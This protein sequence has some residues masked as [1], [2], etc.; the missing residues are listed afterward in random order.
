MQLCPSHQMAA[1]PRAMT[2]SGTGLR[3]PT[4]SGGPVERPR[5][6][7]ASSSGSDGQAAAQGHLPALTPGNCV[8]LCGPQA[9]QP[10]PI[11]S[12]AL[13]TTGDR[14]FSR[15]W[16]ARQ[17]PCP[18]DAVA[19]GWSTDQ[20]D[21]CRDGAQACPQGGDGGDR[22]GPRLGAGGWHG[23]QARGRGNQAGEGRSIRDQGPRGSEVSR[24][25]M[26]PTEVG[27][28][29]GYLWAGR[30]CL[31][32]TD[33]RPNAEKRR[34]YLCRVHALFTQRPGAARCPW[35]PARAASSRTPSQHRAGGPLPTFLP[36]FI[37]GSS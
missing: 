14:E 7:A 6:R 9:D 33:R 8:L 27:G 22:R 1:P 11:P 20:Q 32:E 4:T 19:R 24:F 21:A 29:P 23:A 18:E 26:S 25:D 2:T 3:L 13:P 17:R 31:G 12:Q 5:L 36:T 37:S 10:H 34:L 15:P 30:G 28:W 16:R 35:H